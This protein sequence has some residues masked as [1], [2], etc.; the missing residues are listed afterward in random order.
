MRRVLLHA[1]VRIDADGTGMGKA[2]GPVRPHPFLDQVRRQRLAQAQPYA[3][4]EP[5]LADIKDEQPAG[6]RREHHQL[7]QE[8]GKV[9]PLDGIV[10]GLV[11]AVEQD[12]PERRG[13]D[14][15]KDGERGPDD[16]SGDGRARK[17]GSDRDELVP[18]AAGLDLSDFRCIHAPPVPRVSALLSPRPCMPRPVAPCGDSTGTK[19]RREAR[20]ATG[21]PW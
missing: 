10:E 12:L 7:M 13:A 9:A 14:D 5:L 16:P 21:T 8:L 6:D 4:V 18:Q 3:L 17:P 20:C 11:P 15:D 19:T 2:E 1:L